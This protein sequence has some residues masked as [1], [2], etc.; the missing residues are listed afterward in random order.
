MLSEAVAC[1][2]LLYVSEKY[3][4]VVRCEIIPDPH[5]KNTSD[6]CSLVLTSFDVHYKNNIKQ[7]TDILACIV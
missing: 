6:L 1:F 3:V 4:K 2:L 7:N 5:E